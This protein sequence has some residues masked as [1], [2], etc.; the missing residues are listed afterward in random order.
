[1]KHDQITAKES[2]YLLYAYISISLFILMSI[3]KMTENLEKALNFNPTVSLLITLN[4]LAFISLYLYNRK[5]S[6]IHKAGSK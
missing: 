4:M 3:S 5:H 2:A 1:M 6:V